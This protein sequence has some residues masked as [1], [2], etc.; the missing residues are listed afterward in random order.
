MKRR[1]LLKILAFGPF[2][3]QVHAQTKA[4]KGIKEMQDNWKALLAPGTEVPNAAEPLKLSKDEWKKRLAPASYDVLREEGTE[5][6]GTSVRA[7]AVRVESE[8][9]QRHG[10]AE[11]L[12]T[13]RRTRR[14]QSR[15]QA[16]LSPH[17]VPLRALRRTP[18]PRLR[19]RPA[20]DRQALLQ[21]RRGAEIHPEGREGV[22]PIRSSS[23]RGRA[24]KWKRTGPSG[25]AFRN[26]LR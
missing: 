18:R 16:D 14:D 13:D 12:R 4:T 15:L 10:L 2:L 1:A 21:Q 9:Q 24:G 20:A 5:R 25:S 17:R 6:A 8:V 11:L 7:A 3:T 23:C 26:C 19:R 22:G